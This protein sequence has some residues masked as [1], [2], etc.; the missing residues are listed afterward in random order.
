VLLDNLQNAETKVNVSGEIRN[1][2]QS[3]IY[4]HQT[5]GPYRNKK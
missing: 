2:H 1:H 5:S 4:L 3:T